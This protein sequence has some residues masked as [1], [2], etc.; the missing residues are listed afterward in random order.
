MK[1]RLILGLFLLLSWTAMTTG[2][3]AVV[4]GNMENESDWYVYD[5]GSDAG[6]TVLATAEFNYTADTCAYGKGG[7]L[8]LSGMSTY[9]NILVWQAVTL[10]CGKTYELSAAFRELTGDATVGTWVQIYVSTEMPVE[11]TDYKP[12]G[13]ANTDKLLGFNSWVN[14]TWGGLDGTFQVDGL[15]RDDGQKIE[16]YTTPGSAGDT[17]AYIGIKAGEYNSPEVPFD[18]LVDELSL[19]GGPTAVESKTGPQPVGFALGQ[20]YPNPFNPVT[21]FSYS[22]PQ[23]SSVTVKVYNLHGEE[24]LCPMNNVR[25]AAGQHRLTVDASGLSSGVYICRLQTGSGTLSRKMTL[26][27]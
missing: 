20:N 4:G 13:G 12:P 6:S 16:F 23:A 8:H 3:E 27:K 5:M 19:N 18:V 2:Q 9:T 24:V 10:E 11:L 25:Q 15:E 14:K 7:C 17:V 1:M 22:L 26:A 21:H